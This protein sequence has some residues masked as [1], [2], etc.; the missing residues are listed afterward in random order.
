MYVVC[1]SIVLMNIQPTR[2]IVFVYQ[3]EPSRRTVEQSILVAKV[4]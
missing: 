2:G 1:S 3:H 4:I